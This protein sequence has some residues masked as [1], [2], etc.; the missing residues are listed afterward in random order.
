MQL[1]GSPEQSGL[2]GRPTEH[3]GAL[4]HTGDLVFAHIGWFFV[5]NPSHPERWCPD[6]LEDPDLVLISRLRE[7]HLIQAEPK[8]ATLE[9]RTTRAFV[10]YF[11]IPSTNP[12]EIRNSPEGATIR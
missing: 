4:R 1:V 12:V 5:P 3:L 6:I 9:L 11:G 7:L 2:C 10:E 8:G